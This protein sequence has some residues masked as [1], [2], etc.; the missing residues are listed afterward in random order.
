MTIF[1]V[2]ELRTHG[3][4]FQTLPWGSTD[5]ELYWELLDLGVASFATDHPKVTLDAVKQY[6]ARKR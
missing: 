3:I 6:Y 1:D 4:L 5:R 2:E